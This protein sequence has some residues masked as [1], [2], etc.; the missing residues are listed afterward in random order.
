M[1]KFLNEGG[2]V[3]KG[4]TDRIKKEDID[5]TL[6]SYFAE[7][8]RVFPKKSNIFSTEYFR[9]IGSV[10]K[11]DYSGD[12]D[13]A[14]DVSR[15]L[16]KDMSDES[17]K[18]WDIE[19]SFVDERFVKL[20]KRARTATDEQ[21]RIKAFLQE[22]SVRINEKSQNIYIDEKKIGPGTVFGLYPQLTPEGED[23]DIG[24]QIDWMIGNIEWLEFSYY[25]NTYAGV[26]KGLHR[27]QLM[28]SLF[29]N[30]GLSFNHTNGVKDK[31][32]GE[33]LA[34]SPNEAIAL[35]NT[36]YNFDI[37]RATLED[38]F[39]LHAFIKANISSEDY[40]S[41][42]DIYLKILDK[43]RADIPEDLQKEWMLRKDNLGLT[44]KFLPDDSKLKQNESFVSYL[45]RVI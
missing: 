11:K 38:Y 43:T 9:P 6:N 15:F 30:K 14:I 19:P 29:V 33:V 21:L 16:D 31:E 12:I 45:K 17:M 32:T 1:K 8:K 44:G 35:L 2:N 18:E 36:T 40:D 23:L 39:K 24:V 5:P 22:L 26:V 20:R 37:T 27:T 7:L 34:T 28:L 4:K 41:L 10:G 42:I 25:S 13:L 3:F